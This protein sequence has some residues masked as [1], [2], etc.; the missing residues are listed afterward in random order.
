MGTDQYRTGADYTFGHTELASKRLAVLARVFRPSS[1]SFLRAVAPPDVRRALDLG[2]GPGHTTRLLSE[3]LP[4]AA[5]TGLDISSELL[6]EAEGAP[7]RGLRYL[8]CDV[9]ADALPAPAADLAYCRFLLSHLLEPLTL[10][11]RWGR[12]IEPGGLLLAEEVETIHPNLPVFRTYL[13]LVEAMLADQGSQLYIGPA[14]TAAKDPEGQER[15]FDRVFELQVPRRDAALMFSMNVPNWRDRPFIRARYS[16]DEI[17][18]L[19]TELQQLASSDGGDPVVWEL[20][21]I[22]WRR[23]ATA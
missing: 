21:Q 16:D 15:C 4:D 5:V 19:E 20:R 17:E 12:E 7:S 3:A 8:R 13:E 18:R 10:I 22:G 9:A 2:C 11:A 14:L 23:L 1:E 6:A